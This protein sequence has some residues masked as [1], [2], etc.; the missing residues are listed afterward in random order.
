MILENDRTTGLFN[1]DI[2]LTLPDAEGNPMACFP[3]N[4][5][6]PLR[7]LPLACLP[8]HE[9]AYAMTVH[10]S[11]GS[12][13][14]RIAL[15]L[16]SQES[17]VLTRELVYTGITRARHGVAVIASSDLLASAIARPTSRESGLAERLAIELH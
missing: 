2:G 10:K 8:K 13:F 5:R 7:C 15:V 12:E 16:P 14:D 1:G 3:G 4:H 11:Q 6:E 17:P 9:W